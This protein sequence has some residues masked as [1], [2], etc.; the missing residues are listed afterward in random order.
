MAGTTRPRPTPED[1]KAQ[2]EALHASITDQIETLVRSDRWVRFLQF[3]QSF[4]TYSLNNLLLILS[5]NPDATAVAGFRQWQGKGRQ[6]RK[7][8]K[9][10]RIFGYSTRKTT[11][12]GE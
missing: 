6:V 11:D 3:A 5:Q 7:G 12:T 4:H 8:E 9:A 10:I 1:R 2:A